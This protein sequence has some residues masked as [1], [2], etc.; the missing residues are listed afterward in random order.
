MAEVIWSDEALSDLQ[1]IGEY[2]ERTS[3]PYAAAIVRKLYDSA[4]YLGEHPK[5]GRK[6]PEIGHESM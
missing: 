3:P 4:E 2:F 1:A 5:L 6:V